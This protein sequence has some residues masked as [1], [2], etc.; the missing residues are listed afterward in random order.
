M[1]RDSR[2]P[3]SK[4]DPFTSTFDRAP[5]R[6]KGPKEISRAAM[7]ILVKALQQRRRPPRPA[8]TAIDRNGK[9]VVPGSGEDHD[10]R[11]DNR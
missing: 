10:R 5:K 8:L 2:P 3:D 6:M 9:A 4:G 1:T 11:D 7:D